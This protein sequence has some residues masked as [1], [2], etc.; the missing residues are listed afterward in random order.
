MTRVQVRLLRLF[1][2]RADQDSPEV[3]TPFAPARRLAAATCGA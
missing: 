3:T 1:N 2:L